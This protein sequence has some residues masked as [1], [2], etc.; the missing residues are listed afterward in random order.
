MTKF[1]KILFSFSFIF[2]SFLPVARAANMGDA[3]L[4]DDKHICAGQYQDSLD[5]VAAKAN[6]QV[7]NEATPLQ[8]TSN[9]ITVLLSL[10]GIIFLIFMVYAGILWTTAGGDEKKVEKAKAIIKQ[11]L[12]GLIIVLGAYA[13]SYFVMGALMSNGKLGPVTPAA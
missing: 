4:V 1:Y 3:F 5:C 9:I 10:L 2:L 8:I 11:T 7:L 13:I 6:Y 12:I